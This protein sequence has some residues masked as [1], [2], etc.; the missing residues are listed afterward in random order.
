MSRANFQIECPYKQPLQRPNWTK[1]QGPIQCSQTKS[2]RASISDECCCVPHLFATNCNHCPKTLTP[3]G[4]SFSRISPP[5]QC[6]N[7]TFGCSSKNLSNS[8]L[9]ACS[10]ELT[11]SLGNSVSQA[12]RQECCL[13]VLRTMSKASRRWKSCFSG[14]EKYWRGWPLGG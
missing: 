4:P 13:H 5:I 9:I 11:L 8:G 7:R 12:L 14:R 10:S 2:S 1:G 6:A 3:C